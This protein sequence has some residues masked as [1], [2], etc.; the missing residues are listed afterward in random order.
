MKN[1]LWAWT[2]LTYA[3]LFFAHSGAV[4]AHRQSASTASSAPVIAVDLSPIVVLPYVADPNVKGP[5]SR[6]RLEDGVETMTTR[7]IGNGDV[8]S[9]DLF[10]LQITQSLEGGYDS[11]NIYDKGIVS[12][13]IMQWCA[14]Y[15]SLTEALKY[16]KRRLLATGQARIWNKY[17]A[18]NGL[19][20]DSKELIAFG[21]PLTTPMEI[22]IAIRGTGKVGKYDP[23]LVDHWAVVLARAGRQPVI[24]SL[25]VEYAS[26][27]VDAV[28]QQRLSEITFHAPGRAGATPEDLAANDPY[29]EALIFALWTNNPQ[30][31]FQYVTE[32]ANAAHKGSAADD[33]SL[34]AP[35]AFRAALYQRCASS[36]F[37]NWQQRAQ[38][39]QEREMEVR[40]AAPY[41][42]T[43]F[44][45]GYQVIVAERKSLRLTE[46]ASRHLTE[47][48]P[49]PIYVLP[50]MPDP[51]ITVP[52]RRTTT[53]GVPWCRYISPIPQQKPDIRNDWLM[54]TEF[55]KESRPDT[56]TASGR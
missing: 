14:R 30:H 17:F 54:P 50:V 2:L 27:I 18:S 6:M 38:L 4:H 26:K 16:V 42:L 15:G 39:V 44:E 9:R 49:L 51:F 37:S 19:D 55:L 1:V 45:Q 52:N 32:A 40:S 33:P 47:D 46:V 11:V 35:G 22:R 8:V 7:K 36:A 56:V 41:E 10:I 12:W 3:F 5:L 48:R 43:P 34:F 23:N 20:V 53:P 25:Q 28:L 21:T 13:G 31:A 29:A 24:E